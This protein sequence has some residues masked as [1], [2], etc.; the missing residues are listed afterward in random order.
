MFYIIKYDTEEVRKKMSSLI[1]ENG[2]FLLDGN[3]FRILSG[4]MHYFRVLPEQW[5]T[6]LK[7]LKEMGLNTIET[8]MAW[9]YHEKEEGK[10]DFSGMLD[11]G[12]Y[13]DLC[14]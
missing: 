7:K 3:P 5:E 9:H 12:A 2:K 14:G 11:A 4:A 6:R 8:Y 1:A 10:F 13:I